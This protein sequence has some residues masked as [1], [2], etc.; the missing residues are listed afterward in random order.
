MAGEI[1]IGTSS[2]AADGW[3]GAFYPK[4]MKSAITLAIIRLASIPWRWIQAPTIRFQL[5]RHGCEPWYE[6][7]EN[8]EVYGTSCRG[9][10]S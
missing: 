1:R 2:F 10:T 4:G 6:F 5:T 3:D 8:N 7:A 9:A